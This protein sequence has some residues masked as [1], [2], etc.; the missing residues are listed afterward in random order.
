MYPT[1]VSAS[2]IV[3]IV[4]DYQ[5]DESF[6]DFGAA[7]TFFR[8]S[9]DPSDTDYSPRFVN[10]SNVYQ[11]YRIRLDLAMD[12]DQT[13]GQIQLRVWM[14]ALTNGVPTKYWT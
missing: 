14:N 7:A 6:F 1:A 13:L 8:V 5:T 10:F 12:P 4:Y 3:S 2:S 9:S 11:N